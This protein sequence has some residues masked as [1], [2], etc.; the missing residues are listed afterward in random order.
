MYY[1]YSLTVLI[2]LS[3]LSGCYQTQPK[4][5]TAAPTADVSVSITQAASVME[6][7]FDSPESIV[8]AL[9]KAHDAKK[10]PFFQAKDRALIDQF[11]VEEIA[12]LIWEDATI[13]AKTGEQA[14]LDAD[15]LYNAQD[16]DIKDFVVHPAQT[17]GDQAEVVV[18]FTNFGEKKEL[19]YLLDN[20]NGKW[21]ISDIFYG[22]GNQLFQ[23]L[24]GRAEEMP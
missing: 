15:P 6:S 19:T 4:D 13:V 11:F 1:I 21:L 9:Y 23:L 8:R 7:V 5:E 10:S 22:D 18:T 2:S 24:S 20:E 14:L 17:D 16:M 12:D 3:S